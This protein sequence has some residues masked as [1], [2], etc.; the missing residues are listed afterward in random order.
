[1]LDHLGGGLALPLQDF[2][3]AQFADDR[4][5][6]VS[7]HRH[8]PVLLSAENTDLEA[9]PVFSGQVTQFLL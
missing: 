6:G 3:L 8:D 4:F 2:S 7:L 5:G 9:G 1:L